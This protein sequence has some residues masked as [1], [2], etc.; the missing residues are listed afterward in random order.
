MSDATKPPV[1]K[2]SPVMKFIT[3]LCGFGVPFRNE[4]LVYT[5]DVYVVGM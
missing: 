1:V 3:S 4:Y 2:Y 5:Q